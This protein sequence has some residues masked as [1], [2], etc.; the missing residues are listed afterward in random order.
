IVSSYRS[1]NSATLALSPQVTDGRSVELDAGLLDLTQGAL[2]VA[3][4]DV[5]RPGRLDD[6]VGVEAL[7]HR[8]EGR[9]LDAV[10]GGE[11]RDH[12]VVDPAIAQELLEA[13]LAPL[14]RRQVRDAEPGVAVLRSLGLEDDVSGHFEVGGELGAPGVVNSV[15]RPPAPVLGEVWRLGWMPVLGVDDG[16]TGGPSPVDLPV[17]DRHHF[18][19]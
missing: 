6:D 14:A 15:D 16:D 3:G 18:L 8:V 10:V 4:G 7:A 17:A 5:D 1:A 19:S 9:L 11:P 2:A 13:G 12:D